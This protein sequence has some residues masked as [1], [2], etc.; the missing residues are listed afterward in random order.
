MAPGCEGRG[1]RICSQAGAD[2]HSSTQAF[3]ECHDVWS[4]P[5]MLVGKESAGPAD[6][7]L[8]FIEDQQRPAFPRN[9]PAGL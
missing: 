1:Y 8:Y 9:V 6:T 2:R 3:R 7:C 5:V 4:D